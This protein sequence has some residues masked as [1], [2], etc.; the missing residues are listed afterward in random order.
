[1]LTPICQPTVHGKTHN[2]RELTVE[3]MNI[4]KISS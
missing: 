3:M 1:M 4:D 2:Q